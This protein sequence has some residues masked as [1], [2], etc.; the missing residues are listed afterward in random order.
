LASGARSSQF[1]RFARNR[2]P[3]TLRPHAHTRRTVKHRLYLISTSARR[4]AAAASTRTIQ[5]I[6]LIGLLGLIVR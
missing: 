5:W 3:T 1:S 4:H 6:L 2:S